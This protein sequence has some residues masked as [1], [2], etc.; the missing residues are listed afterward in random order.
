MSWRESSAR[1]T[2]LLV[3]PWDC[4]LESRSLLTPENS[5]IGPRKFPVQFKA[6]IDY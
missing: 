5:L 6:P 2:A 1:A 3:T 4:S